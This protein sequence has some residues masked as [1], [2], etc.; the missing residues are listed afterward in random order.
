MNTYRMREGK[1]FKS[2]KDEMEE[3]LNK[4]KDQF[5]TSGL[6]RKLK[7]FSKTFKNGPI[8]IRDSYLEFT[9]IYAEDSQ[10]YFQKEVERTLRE[11]H[12][13]V[14]LEKDGKTAKLPNKKLKKTE[15]DVR[16]W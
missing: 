15:E 13:I 5:D 8:A 11:I 3:L 16:L 4:G 2:K 9:R 14:I 1:Y 7:D 12:K 10:N 6:R